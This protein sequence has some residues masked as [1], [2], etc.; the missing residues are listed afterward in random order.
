MKSKKRLSSGRRRGTLHHYFIP[1]VHNVY[2]PLYTVVAGTIDGIQLAQTTFTD[3][4]GQNLDQC[5]NGKFTTFPAFLTNLSTPCGTNANEAWANGNINANNSAYREGD[6]IPYRF[7]A[8]KLPNGTHTVIVDYDFTK[9]GI[10]AIDR[11]TGYQITQQ[12][13]PCSPRRTS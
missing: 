4:V 7:A 3:N 10:F 8:T 9:A 11:L 1:G 13:S 6:G 5:Q 12:S 2:R